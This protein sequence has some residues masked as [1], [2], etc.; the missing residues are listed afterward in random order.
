[1][2]DLLRVEDELRVEDLLR[3]EEPEEPVI[4][5]NHHIHDIVIF[6]VFITSFVIPL[7]EVVTKCNNNYYFTTVHSKWRDVT[8]CH[9]PSRLTA[10][11]YYCI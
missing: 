11:L 7:G 8:V 2:E 5:C 4:M 1:M 9:H 10:L 6:L 3:V